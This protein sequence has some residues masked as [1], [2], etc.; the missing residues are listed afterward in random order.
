M[1]FD[2]INAEEEAVQSLME[3]YAQ[4][5]KCQQLYERAGMAIPEALQRFLGM[6]GNSQK[7]MGHV[8]TTAS[9]PAP[10]R[11]KEPEGAEPDWIWIN[12][13]DATPTSVVLAILRAAKGPV[14][15]KDVVS[16]VTDLLHTVSSGSVSN[17]GTRLEGKL[18]ERA[19]DGWKLLDPTKA[20]IIRDGSLWGPP[21]IFSKQE[22]AAHRRDAILHVLR[23]F[24]SGLQTVQIVE[25]LYNC[26]WVQAP[27]NK[28]L[29]KAD[30]EV[31]M[32]AKKVR[33]RGNTKKWEIVPEEKAVRN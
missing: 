4:T 1:N 11:P 20:G 15:P 24:P 22:L 32:T 2:R 30:L 28:D 18:I 5:K 19:P 6:N 14:R 31:L 27:I 10:T 8:R 16:G 7:A 23:L 13:K 25:Q 3:L 17:I 26:S 21:V 33:R 29:L 12:A 9:I